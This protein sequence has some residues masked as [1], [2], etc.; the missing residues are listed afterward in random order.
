MIEKKKSK[1]KLFCKSKIWLLSLLFAC[2][3]TLT[4]VWAKNSGFSEFLYYVRRPIYIFGFLGLTIELALKY[5]RFS[6]WLFTFLCWTT[7]LTVVV[8]FFWFYSDKPFAHDRLSLV[9]D[10]LQNPVAAGSVLGMVALV[11][12]YNNLTT[13]K[14]TTWV[15]LGLLI[16]TLLAMGLTKSRAPLVALL[17]TWTVG[18][19]WT[20]DK[21]VLFALL[22]ITVLA[23]F[24]F[25]QF[26]SIKSEIT[27]P[28]LDIRWDIWKQAVERIQDA[29]FFGEGISTDTLF[30]VSDGSTWNHTHN[31]Y[32]G[33][34]LYGGLVGLGLLLTLLFVG[35]RQAILF[36]SREKN[37]IYLALLLFAGICMLSGNYRITSHP[38]AIW[39]YFWVPMAILAADEIFSHKQ[40]E[41]YVRTP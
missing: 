14:Q 23:G 38:D 35:T 37:F 40:G 2:Y 10:Q 11:C 4:L 17:V 16:V 39:L 41:Q 26:S 22:G 7:V 29:P 32:I 12:Y 28:G 31:V 8:S 1:L 24:A 18:S 13:K 15:Y 36:Y 9:G 19:L 20:R 5:P 33:T 21:K 25:F 27:R 30:T 3:L 6:D 34:A